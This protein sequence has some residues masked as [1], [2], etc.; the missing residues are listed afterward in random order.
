MCRPRTRDSIPR[1][2]PLFFSEAAFALRRP[3][4][5]SPCRRTR[6]LWQA[7]QRKDPLPP[8]P[9]DGPSRRFRGEGQ[10]PPAFPLSPLRSL[11][12]SLLLRSRS[13]EV[14]NTIC[15]QCGPLTTKV[16]E[17]KERG[18]IRAACDHQT[19]RY[20]TL[21]TENGGLAIYCIIPTPKVQNRKGW[22]E[23][24]CWHCRLRRHSTFRHQ[25][26][27]CFFLSWLR[28]KLGQDREPFSNIPRIKLSTHGLGMEGEVSG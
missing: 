7:E 20:I 2:R 12:S 17:H 26:E 11:M 19:V 4:R 15:L 23:R 28:M 5:P 22:L 6:P 16:E 9:A 27:S 18:A 24:Y 13:L 3:L 25:S 10:T 14:Q 1:G 8:P 21:L